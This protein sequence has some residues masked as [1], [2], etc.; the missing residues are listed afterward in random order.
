MIA[1]SILVQ[2]E[3]GAI[4]GSTPANTWVSAYRPIYFRVMADTLCPPEQPMYCDI[5]MLY[6]TIPYYK[7]IT[8]YSIENMGGTNSIFEFDLQDAY[9]EW[10]KTFI[11]ETFVTSAGI[12]STYTGIGSTA[13][14]S[15]IESFVRFRGSSFV[16]GVLVPESPI[17]VQGTATTPPIAG[18]GFL[19][20]RFGIVNSTLAPNSLIDNVGG[21]N[22]L[23]NTLKYYQYIGGSGYLVNRVYPLS[24]IPPNLWIVPLGSTSLNVRPEL[25]P[26]VYAGDSGL[27]P[28]LAIRFG[29]Y[30][31]FP[32]DYRN[33]SLWIHYG[34]GANQSPSVIKKLINSQLITYGTY[35][36]PYG[37]KEI[38]SLDPTLIP[39][40]TD[41]NQDYYYYIFL[42]DDTANKI[43]FFTP[44]F[45]ARNGAVEKYR[46][47]FQ[48]YY[49]H[50]EQVTFLR[51]TEKHKTTSSEQYT[52]LPINNFS[53]LGGA[54][55]TKV[56]N[57]G[58]KR[59][60]VRV[61][62]EI[63]L[64][65]TFSELLMPW[66]KELMDS[67]LCM[68]DVPKGSAPAMYS[69]TFYNLKSYEVID[70][71]FQTR[72]TVSEGRTNYVVTIKIR[73]AQQTIQLRN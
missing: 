58:K 13:T 50:F 20:H 63:S 68:V 61:E 39:I 73:P 31:S 26:E 1:I 47:W 19:S 18:G 36:I 70:G 51:N 30:L 8:A 12:L 25:C 48:N 37:L 43:C 29:T 45:R 24:N 17:P 44:T 6:G 23:E 46:L 35:Y 3:M 42:V 72:K 56:I 10:I 33:V 57:S 67:P 41:V 69:G 9:Q 38:E 59:Y 11:P 40:L 49:G 4:S 71:S 5:Y 64:T 53:P 32:T 16:S 52:P 15:I 21:L 66:L 7:T 22:E 65:A 27:F 34:N 55:P 54:D 2:P 28:L 14:T 60:N 62:D